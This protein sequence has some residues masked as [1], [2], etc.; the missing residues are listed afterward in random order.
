VIDGNLVID[1]E[2]MVA[3]GIKSLRFEFGD[4]QT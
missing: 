1:H 3:A 2:A 4:H